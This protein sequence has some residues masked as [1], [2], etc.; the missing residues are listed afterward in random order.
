MKNRFLIVSDPWLGSETNAGD[1][2]A[3]LFL[4]AY[5]RLPLEIYVRS[6][7]RQNLDS[8]F[9]NS[10]RDL[11]GL[12]AGT[13]ILCCGW[14]DAQTNHSALEIQSA[15]QRL[16]NELLHN[17]PAQLV[18]C[19]Y[20]HNQY[21]N[22]PLLRSKLASIAE[23]QKEYS[24]HERVRLAPVDASF[25][26]YQE[27]QKNREESARSLFLES[28]ELNSLGQNIWAHLLFQQLKVDSPR[29]LLS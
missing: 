26:Q 17:S 9:H 23:C 4:L 12:Q 10:A 6:S 7:S 1:L 20:P 8:L 5:P 25:V 11:I 14:L 16:V 24:M 27:L 15:Y 3:N 21:A 29:F 28:G 19:D 13:I 2:L 18:L 22:E